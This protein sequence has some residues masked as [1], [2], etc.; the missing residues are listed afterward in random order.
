MKPVVF[1]AGLF[2]AVALSASA[3]AQTPPRIPTRL[4][5]STSSWPHRQ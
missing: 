4:R 5:S 2:A 1:L 3:S